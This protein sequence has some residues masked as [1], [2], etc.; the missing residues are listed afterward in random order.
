MTK[1]VTFTPEALQQVIAE[2]VAVAL[3]ARD[4]KPPANKLV[5]GRTEQQL[6]IDIMVVK[7][8]VRT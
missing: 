3:A 5:D 4:A 1:E 2:A 7:A 8:R 6:K